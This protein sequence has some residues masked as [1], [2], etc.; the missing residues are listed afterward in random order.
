MDRQQIGMKLTLEALGIPFRLDTF[1]DRLILQKAIYL[2]QAGGIQLGYSYRWYLR[3]P[4]STGLTRDA[5]SVKAEIAGGDDESDGWNLDD[6]SIRHAQRVRGLV[7]GDRTPEQ[8]E[9]L[10]LLASVHYVVTRR[11][12]PPRAIAQIVEALKHLGKQVDEDGVSEGLKAL[13]K[14]ELIPETSV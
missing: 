1:N 7:G 13:K 11:H 6:G 5:F 2:A 12:N 8:A 3:G 10:E 9:R 14:Y 4:Y